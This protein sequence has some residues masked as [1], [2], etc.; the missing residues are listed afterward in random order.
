LV[1]MGCDTA[2][3]FLLARPMEAD[4]FV[5]MLHAGGRALGGPV[6]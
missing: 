4:A 3:G 5:K 1:A 2:Q 6:K